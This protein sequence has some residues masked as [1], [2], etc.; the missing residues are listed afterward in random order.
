MGKV[1]ESLIVGDLLI[2]E[3]CLKNE[4]VKWDYKFYF[5]IH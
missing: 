2:Q 1:S 4:T 3:F 5:L